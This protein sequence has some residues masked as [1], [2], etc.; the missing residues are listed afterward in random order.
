MDLIST[1]AEAKSSVVSSWKPLE[2]E[3]CEA[4][5]AKASKEDPHVTVNLL[6]YEWI[7]YFPTYY[8]R[9]LGKLT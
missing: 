7:L 5:N 3:D 2:L 8:S 9:I 1:Y 6:Q 4:S